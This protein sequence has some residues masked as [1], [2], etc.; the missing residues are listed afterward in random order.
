VLILLT[1]GEAA[2]SATTPPPSYLLIYTTGNGGQTWMPQPLVQMRV[3]QA[4]FSD[5]QHGWAL[6]NPN[7]PGVSACSSTA[8]ADRRGAAAPASAPQP[9]ALEGTAD[10][11][12]HW[13]QLNSSVNW[14]DLTTLDFVSPQQGWALLGG[15][16]APT[17]LLRTSDGGLTWT[18]LPWQSA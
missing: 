11:G 4:A 16:G 7:P 15:P 18:S 12:Q 13:T 5:P 6:V 14:C 3:L 9:N 17:T 10:G 2:P 1:T 8:A